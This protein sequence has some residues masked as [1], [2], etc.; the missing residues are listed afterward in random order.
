M[1][2]PNNCETCDH[3]RIPQGGWCYM[4]RDEP[5]D[6]CGVHTGR[7]KSI[8]AILQHYGIDMPGDDDGEDSP[9][10]PAAD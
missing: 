8:G 6:V 1:S 10:V 2:N 4:F 5:A 3:K 9:R 7:K